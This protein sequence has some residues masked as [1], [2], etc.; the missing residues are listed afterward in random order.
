MQTLSSHPKHFLTDKKNLHIYTETKEGSLGEPTCLFSQLSQYASDKINTVG[1]S[2]LYSL[3]ECLQFGI[4]TSP[5]LEAF[6]QKNW[7]PSFAPRATPMDRRSPTPQLILCQQRGGLARK[8]VPGP[9]PGARGAG[10]VRGCV[11]CVCSVYWGWRQGEGC[12]LR[13]SSES[14]DGIQGSLGT[15]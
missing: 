8:A 15:I 4:N 13:C 7:C 5:S 6:G 9:K 10:C 12:C 14:N 11:W 1:L 3:R 2:V